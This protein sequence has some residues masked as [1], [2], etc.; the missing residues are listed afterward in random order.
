MNSHFT[1]PFK[2]I[3][4]YS[5]LIV[6]LH[7]SFIA[8]AQD[9]FTTYFNSKD[10]D[11]SWVLPAEDVVVKRI[12]DVRPTKNKAKHNKSS[13]VYNNEEDKVSSKS[14]VFKADLDEGLIGAS[15]EAST[16]HPSDNVFKLE[17]DQVNS[18]EQAILT[19][20][21][22]GVHPVS[23]ASQL[24]QQPTTGGYIQTQNED[25]IAHEEYINIGDLKQE[26][27]YIQFNANG[28]TAQP[29]KIKN[30]QIE[31]L[32]GQSKE[33]DSKIIINDFYQVK[34]NWLYVKGFINKH[35]SSE[36]YKLVYGG[37]E[38]NL[39]HGVFEG[40]FEKS[41]LENSTL[42]LSSKHSS[43][44]EELDLP[45]KQADQIEAN[46]IFTRLDFPEQ[47]PLLN[48]VENSFENTFA[49]TLVTPTD[50][51]Y[52]SKLRPLDMMPLHSGIKHLSQH[53]QGI[54]I[55][56]NSTHPK[57]VQLEFKLKDSLN[58]K[59]IRLADVQTFYFDKKLK[60]WRSLKKDTLDVL[61]QSFKST[62][63]IDGGDQVDY[64]NGVIETPEHPES[65]AF[66]PTRISDLE[67]VQ[68]T[69]GMNLMSPPQ[70]TQTGEANI[71]YPLELPPGRKGMM[72]QINL[73]Y[74][75]DA[76]S[77]WV[78]L[79]WNVN[80]PS[81]NVNPKWG[82]PQFDTSKETEVYSFMGEMLI[83]EDN[84]LPHR[85]EGSGQN[86]STDL[87]D[88]TADA[89]FF[90]RRHSDQTKIERMGN[91]PS[92]YYWKVT[93]TSGKITWF[94]GDE[95]GINANATLT[96]ADGN[97]VQWGVVK[98]IDTYGNYVSYTYDND[99]VSDTNSN[100]DEGKYFYPLSIE[101][102]KNDQ[103]A[104][105]GNYRVEFERSSTYREDPKVIGNRGFKE[106]DPYLLEKIK[107]LYDN[108]AVRTYEL[109]YGNELG[110]FYKT[111][112]HKLKY[113][114]ENDDLFYE[115]EF[116]YYDDLAENSEVGAGEGDIYANGL[117]QD[118]QNSDYLEAIYD[119]DFFSDFLNNTSNLNLLEP[120]LLSTNQGKSLRGGVRPSVGIEFISATNNEARTLTIG[121]DLAYSYS[122]TTGKIKLADINGDG[123]QDLVFKS[124]SNIK[125]FK[126]YLEENG[127]NSLL[128]LNFETDPLETE[129]MKH[130]YKSTSE[131]IPGL[132]NVSLAFKGFNAS[133]N[134]NKTKTVTDVYMTDAN[135]DGLVDIVAGNTVH[136][137]YIDEDGI[138]NF[139]TNSRLTENM[140]VS[141]GSGID[142][143]WS[144]PNEDN[145]KH[146][147]DEI[148]E[149][150]EGI[151]DY[152]A[153]HTWIAPADGEVI[154]EG[155]YGNLDSSNTQNT[156]LVAETQSDELN[157]AKPFR[158]L[159]RPMP[160]IETNWDFF[161]IDNF[162]LQGQVP[163]GLDTS[164]NITHVR[165]GQKLFFRYL[166]NQQ[167]NNMGLV[168]NIKYL[169]Q[170]ENLSE[171]F[172]LDGGSI[173]QTQDDFLLD[174]KPVFVENPSNMN[175]T[176]DDFVIENP[177]D[178]IQFEIKQI[179][180]DETNNEQI[181]NTIYSKTVTVNGNAFLN[182]I[183]SN[184]INTFLIQNEPSVF[185]FIVK[186]DT[187]INYKNENPPITDYYY[188]DNFY[189]IKDWRP[190][191]QI[192]SNQDNWQYPIPVHST[193]WRMTSQN[194][195]NFTGQSIA[196]NPTL[197]DD[198]YRANPVQ[199]N[200]AL[201]NVNKEGEF[202]F[203]IEKNDP[204]TSYNQIIDKVSISVDE[205][206][207]LSF[208][209]SNEQVFNSD[210][211]AIQES[212]SIRFNYY[213][214][215]DHNKELLQK[216]LEE[217]GYDTS[218]FI[219]SLSSQFF[220]FFTGAT[221]YYNTN[222]HLGSM[223]GNRGMFFYNDQVVENDMPEDG[224]GKLINQESVFEGA[225]PDLDD[226]FGLDDNTT[227]DDIALQFG[228]ENIPTQEEF[229]NG[230]TIELPD[231]EVV[232]DDIDGNFSIPKLEVFF[233]S[234]VSKLENGIKDRMIGMYDTQ[235]VASHRLGSHHVEIDIT[236]PESMPATG[237]MEELID[238]EEEDFVVQ[239]AD[240][241]AG[242]RAVKLRSR[243]RSNSV[244]AGYIGVGNLTTIETQYNYQSTNFI[245]LNGDGYPDN[246]Y[247]KEIYYTNMTGGHTPAVNNV[248]ENHY[249][250]YSSVDNHV[251]FN[252]PFASNNI[253]A[254]E[255]NNKN[256][257]SLIGLPSDA[258]G[259][260]FDPDISFGG[261]TQNDIY[262]MDVN[263]DGLSDKIMVSGSNIQMK[264]NFGNI[265]QSFSN[266]PT[267]ND[268]LKNINS[269]SSSNNF[270]ISGNFFQGLDN[271][272][273]SASLGLT[274]DRSS[275]D[276][277][278]VDLNG[279]GLVDIVELNMSILSPNSSVKI[280]KGDSFSNETIEFNQNLFNSTSTLSG[281]AGVRA[282]LF[283]HLPKILLFGVPIMYLK[284]G[285]TGFGD[286]SLSHSKTDKSFVDVNGDGF[287]DFVESDGSKM[288]VYYSR[289]GRTNK[290]KTVHN[291]ING[292]FTLDYKP[293]V[294]TYG[295]P[296]TKWAL[297][298]VEVN[299]GYDFEHGGSQIVRKDYEY[300]NGK[301]DRREREFLGYEEVRALDYNYNQEGEM[302][303]LYRGTIKRYH[304]QNYHLNGLLKEKI[305]FRS[306]T[307]EPG[308]DPEQIF[309]KNTYTY[310]LFTFNQD[311]E[312]D[313]ANP[314]AL[315][316]DTGGQEGRART[317]TLLIEKLEEYFEFDSDQIAKKHEY[318]YNGL[319]LVT[320]Y[321]NHG[322]LSI[323][324]DD[325][326]TSISYHDDAGLLDK[327]II[328]IPKVLEVYDNSNNLKR[329]RVTDDINV[330]T[331]NIGEMKMSIDSS[332]DAEYDL[333]YDNYGNLSS[334]EYP[335]NI[336]NQRVIYNYTYDNKE[337]TYVISVSDHFNYVSNFEYE[338][339]YGNLL[340]ETDYAGN[341]INYSYDDKGRLI[342]I[343]APNEQDNNQDYTVS[344]E[345]FITPGLAI[346][347]P[348]APAF[349]PY[350]ITKHNSYQI[351]NNA[352]AS[353]DTYT[354]VDGMN[355]VVQV[356]NDHV[357]GGSS[358]VMIISGWNTYDNFGRVVTTNHPHHEPKDPNINNQ[359]N[360]DLPANNYTS[361]IAYDWVDRESRIIN[362][363]GAITRIYYEISDDLN[364]LSFRQRVI[365]PEDMISHEYTDVKGQTIESRV[366][367]VEDMIVRYQYNSIGELTAYA[368]AEDLPTSYEYDMLG[369]Q[370]KITNQ[371]FNTIDIFYDKASNITKKITANLD[372][373][374]ESIDYDY[375]YNR[376]TSIT[377]PEI[378]GMPNL[379][380]VEYFYGNSGNETGRLIEQTD[381]T[382]QMEYKYGNMGE[383]VETTRTI[384]A[385]NLPDRYFITRY[386][387][388][389]W[390]RILRM[391]YPDEEAVDYVYNEAGALDKIIGDE[392]YIRNIDYDK[393]GH[394]VIVE[395]GNQ[396]I[397]RF[398][399]TPEMQRLSEKQVFDINSNLL[400]DRSYSY[401][402][403]GNVTRYR[404]NAGVY[405]GSQDPAGVMGGN[406]EFNF[407]YDDQNRLQT[408]DGLFDGDP[409]QQQFG[410]NFMSNFKLSMDYTSTGGIKGKD[411]KHVQDNAINNN[412]TY[413]NV[414]TYFDNTHKVKNIKDQNSG[415][416][417][418]FDYDLNGNMI[419]A[420]DGQSFENNYYWDEEN[421]LRVVKDINLMHHYIY[422]ANGERVLKS[423]SNFISVE[424]NGTVIG[425]ETAFQNYT[426][427]ASPQIVIDAN[428]NY[429]KHYFEADTRIVTRLGGDA[430]LFQNPPTPPRPASTGDSGAD[431]KELDTKKLKDL[432]KSDLVHYFKKAEI[433]ST[434]SFKPFKNNSVVTQN[435]EDDATEALE[436][437]LGLETFSEPQTNNQASAIF[438]YHA[439]HL[440]SNEVISD[441]TGAPHEFHL[442]LPFGETMVEQRKPMANY[443]NSWK[444][445][446]KELDE[447]TGLY[448]FGA[449][450]YQPSWSIWLSVD[451]L[452]EQAPDWTPYR[453]GFNNPIK[454]IDPDGMFE[455]T[456][457]E[458]EETGEEVEVKD[459]VDKRVKVDQE[460]FDQ[461][462]EYAKLGE[463][464]NTNENWNS[465]KFH[466]YKQFYH[467]ALYGDTFGER[468]TNFGRYFSD[469]I[470][471]EILD[472]GLKDPYMIEAVLEDYGMLSGGLGNAKRVPQ[473]IKHVK[474]PKKVV[475]I[476]ED[477]LNRV[478]PYAKKNGF[479]YFKPRGKNPAN[480]MKNQK[481][482]IRRQLND[483]STEIINIGPKGKTAS[484]KY[485]KAEIKAI[486]KYLSR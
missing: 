27:N 57:E 100:L 165:K 97:I 185:Q 383:V 85:H 68:P 265:H 323:N 288:T 271:F 84:Y 371:D 173:Q 384:V 213:A 356:K 296:N 34:D 32:K 430:S 67:P 246:F 201:P 355:R 297:T 222:K 357:L 110:R 94:G 241:V 145:E 317:T 63:Q 218:V 174:D 128:E 463:L 149:D 239:D 229:E 461:A 396:N 111:L 208:T 435:E 139:T 343:L 484:S 35:S 352:N 326:S 261:K 451:P 465:E 132:D 52:Y 342:K 468:L 382:G 398:T 248:E 134:E 363:E 55:K 12:K 274:T 428:N 459:N 117:T 400:F 11:L 335:E 345:Y 486:I 108:E 337:K 419:F 212:E 77:G 2:K 470:V 160:S 177:K 455:D 479:K 374:N 429:T 93:N 192:G 277:T 75:S 70:V 137:N 446:G 190:V 354:F 309:S 258:L 450:Y 183:S 351:D 54:S 322:D 418:V 482:W 17:L 194:S 264:Y 9:I 105:L 460:T 221:E 236:S 281:S 211:Y 31:L 385:P 203:T 333:T 237:G 168:Y 458:N 294:K 86:V 306:N 144:D 388:D 249:S 224:F 312:I 269:G 304:N 436:E 157:N 51:L 56:N 133:K 449:R 367:G 143:T 254:G 431:G 282:G 232:L 46:Q 39:E 158:F 243:T 311:N 256:G 464:N 285:V 89:R 432:Q 166:G 476:G 141:E 124:G 155:R 88:R 76:Q 262:Y 22:Y 41:Q 50:S 427:Y 393:F 365:A 412:N 350:S 209:E 62:L 227:E 191:I 140:L 251:K 127:E 394:R 43:F 3:A 171:S 196:G 58:S 125:F 71:N 472:S 307:P 364:Q 392:I 199:P 469:G 116:E 202:L 330:N 411:Q 152:D 66:A 193:F 407:T 25:W 321:I 314:V 180:F 478:I 263:G 7:W 480:W 399:Y 266:Q 161:T 404:G 406:Y 33:N 473:I 147:L 375:D 235:R 292:S 395:L 415:L 197:T 361:S 313:I 6:T 409:S 444:F 19:Y 244:S 42:S 219:E 216:Y 189:K 338:M 376:P 397:E 439:D 471:D 223:I 79:G 59:D 474:N 260:N 60:S 29:Y 78:G 112:L 170:H 115:H 453:Y 61:N 206:G 273:L 69:A 122:P 422:D 119:N 433:E 327:N 242:M 230:Q 310:E 182:T 358:Q 120:S 410:N 447:E 283:F 13:L 217:V 169:N 300:H 45:L 298:N 178:N 318:E 118:F 445:T 38:V 344:Y 257:K 80:L 467:S 466:E 163:L 475:V 402:Q 268:L 414:Y 381:A 286:V 44:L 379:A 123:V 279:D 98:E 373:I 353:I 154:I 324:N 15:S 129:G 103:D 424:E 339:K 233:G 109:D 159:F 278:Y 334:I 21:V 331:G 53:P 135:N 320:K 443:Y 380:N 425:N 207:I 136:F 48:E 176:W 73:S 5:I 204:N 329:K 280:N 369:R 126:G 30:V 1:T 250:T 316:F 440:G 413:N 253:P 40:F 377:Y 95:N 301:Y 348:E 156:F 65:N 92:S 368:D 438:F 481:Q 225:T 370:V 420:T 452:A 104:N 81:I 259:V 290:L 405:Q 362:A 426:T 4:Y 349:V 215:G 276:E 485:Y 184:D 336:N 49:F 72:P 272:S 121:T 20:K 328:G 325:Y 82:V 162:D 360:T 90:T 287:V 247:P 378:Q 91:S 186:S 172:G 477:M 107:V 10:F 114:D 437:L 113:L 340:K 131:V 23:V 179:Y 200:N 210:P 153:V 457:Y 167:A 138:P 148:K 387:Y 240:A 102:T 434:P 454:Y 389:S 142:L 146:E 187:E 220:T 403:L 308:E 64:I 275:V 448:Y 442:T 164:S 302:T 26:A 416:I 16:D 295:N 366:S 106:V 47:Y 101:Y 315:D 151:S 83:Y 421:R 8:P 391:I 372:D 332:T 234:P 214:V 150:L 130:F 36:E 245:D 284:G 28:S 238:M 319:G 386:E 14:E 231:I 205:N 198:P 408:A 37:N 305:V 195:I 181:I 24:N 456:I 417:T 347:D 99:S 289:I 18:S 270:G 401:D 87:R 441:E 96:D 188:N 293:Q 346:P 291:P 390:N 462:K 303:S 252:A 74:N 175:I 255:E 423:S 359:I 483:P 267:E 299:S 226:F 228:L 341:E